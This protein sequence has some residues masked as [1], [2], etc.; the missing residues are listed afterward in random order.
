MDQEWL[1]S[2]IGNLTPFVT[3]LLSSSF[4]C[5]TDNI[6]TSIFFFESKLDSTIPSKYQQ[7][8]A[9]LFAAV[10]N[11]FGNQTGGW[12]IHPLNAFLTS[13]NEVKS[14]FNNGWLLYLLGSEGA[15]KKYKGITLEYNVKCIATMLYSIIFITRNKDAID[16]LALSL[17]AEGGSDDRR[18]RYLDDIAQ[19]TV[20][21]YFEI[22]SSSK[23]NGTTTIGDAAT[24]TTA[25]LT[26]LS[27][28]ESNR[29]NANSP[30][31]TTSSLY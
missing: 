17:G 6:T 29:I 25:S 26:Q 2:I 24:T 12:D 4:A 1:K 16:L 27:S 5:H 19:N 11:F 15:G 28:S 20:Q 14:Q 8:K 9:D 7:T 3:F 18:K 23:S 10:E 30:T 13:N 22:Q 31:K 21:Q